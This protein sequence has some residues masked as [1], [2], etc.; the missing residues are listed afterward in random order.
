MKKLLLSVLLGVSISAAHAVG[1]APFSFWKMAAAGFTSRISVTGA[2]FD[3][4]WINRDAGTTYSASKIVP[5]ASYTISKV[6][7]PLFKTGSPTFSMTCAIYTDSSGAPGTLVGTASTA[8]VAS[9]VPATLSTDV[10]FTGI[11]ASV[12][13]GTSYWVVI[14]KSSGTDNYSVDYVS[15][16]FVNNSSGTTYKTM[17]ST[18]GTS[19][20]DSSNHIGGFDMPGRVTVYS[21]P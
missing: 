2:Q 19:W 3:V 4:L 11:S 16:P 12:T 21:T 7:A 10:D 13:S 15:W 6:G 9:T 8:V 20:A 14:Y 18:A 1:P 17:S 5:A